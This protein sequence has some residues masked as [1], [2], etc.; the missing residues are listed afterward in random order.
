M[1]TD[2]DTKKYSNNYFH[3]LKNSTSNTSFSSM[4]AFC[5]IKMQDRVGSGERLTVIRSCTR[6]KA[7][8]LINPTAEQ[9]KDT[10]VKYKSLKAIPTHPI[11]LFIRADTNIFNW[12]TTCHWWHHKEPAQR[13]L[14]LKKTQSFCSVHLVWVVFKDVCFSDFHLMFCSLVMKSNT[15]IKL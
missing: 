3:C 5:V 1:Q 12:Q 4:I 14:Q 7:C 2:L 11:F 6:N 13:Q 8:V 15:R 10:M 9:T